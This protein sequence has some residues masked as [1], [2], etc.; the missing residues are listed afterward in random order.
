MHSLDRET[1][2]T[3]FKAAFTAIPKTT[4]LSGSILL[5]KYTS[6]PDEIAMPSGLKGYCRTPEVLLACL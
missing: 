5:T 4:E 6:Q 2:E 1:T 3:R